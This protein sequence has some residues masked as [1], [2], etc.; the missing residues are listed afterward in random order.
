LIK[1]VLDQKKDRIKKRRANTSTQRT[2]EIDHDTRRATLGGGAAGIPIVTLPSLIK[3]SC[4]YQSN[5]D[6]LP[7]LLKRPRKEA[8]SALPEV[9]LIVRYFSR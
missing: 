8:D 9:A 5:K 3:S 2:P 7:N 1:T 6:Y 4:F